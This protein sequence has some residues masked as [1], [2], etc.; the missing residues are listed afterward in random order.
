MHWYLIRETKISLIEHK[1]IY[2]AFGKSYYDDTD[3]IK[4]KN[5]SKKGLSL[6]K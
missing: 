1:E 6:L 2:V 3:K 4:A 5:H